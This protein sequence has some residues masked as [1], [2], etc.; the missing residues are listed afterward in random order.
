MQQLEKGSASQL[1]AAAQHLEEDELRQ[2]LATFIQQQK[3]NKK[4]DVKKLMQFLKTHAS[5]KD[6]LIAAIDAAHKEYALAQLAVYEESKDLLKKMA[7][8]GMNLVGKFVADAMAKTQREMG[9]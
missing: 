3:H 8:Q 2:L 7:A 5:A 4:E 1:A 9:R 6:T